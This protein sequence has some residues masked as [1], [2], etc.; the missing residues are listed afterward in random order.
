MSTTTITTLQSADQDIPLQLRG[1]PVDSFPR[2]SGEV[3]GDDERNLLALQTPQA[4]S[5][6]ESEQRED[7][8]QR[9]I[10][11]NSHVNASKAEGWQI[12]LNAVQVLLGSVSLVGFL[13]MLYPQIIS[14]KL[15]QWTAEKDFR[16]EC[17]T[18]MVS[19]LKWK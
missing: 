12:R 14:L 2:E 7:T 11:P 4:P 6:S 19:V 15:A 18:L 9:G 1:Q 16:D 17:R 13:V 3:R 8:N 10:L 5:S